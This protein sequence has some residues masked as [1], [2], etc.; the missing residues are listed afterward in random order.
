M[1]TAPELADDSPVQVNDAPDSVDDFGI[2]MNRMGRAIAC[3]AILF[4]IA[5]VA[6]QVYIRF[7]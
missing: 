2:W 7:H 6:A 4:L 1:N 3:L 5:M